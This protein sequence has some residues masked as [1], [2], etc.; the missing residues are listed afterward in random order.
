MATLSPRSVAA[1]ELDR[2]LNASDLYRL[3]ET[4]SARVRE[5]LLLEDVRTVVPETT[6]ASLA[7]GGTRAPF[8]A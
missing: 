2:R 5:A 4:L 6:T 3:L 7:P 8:K 1:H